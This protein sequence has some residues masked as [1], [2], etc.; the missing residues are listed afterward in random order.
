[1]SKYTPEEVR[2]L[3]TVRD[4]IL[5]RPQFYQAGADFLVAEFGP[6]RLYQKAV[7]DWER[8]KDHPTEI[9]ANQAIARK[10]TRLTSDPELES[11][12]RDRIDRENYAAITRMPDRAKFTTGQSACKAIQALL[13]GE[14]GTH[15]DV[16]AKAILL[17]AVMLWDNDVHTRHPIFSAFGDWGV[18]P[19][20][21]VETIDRWAATYFLD[22]LDSRKSLD[23]WMA[24]VQMAW[25]GLIH[26]DSPDPAWEAAVQKFRDLPISAEIKDPLVKVFQTVVRQPESFRSA[27]SEVQKLIADGQEKARQ[28]GMTDDWSFWTRE[29]LTDVADEVTTGL[30]L[31]AFV[32]W[33]KRLS[34][35]LAI[36][37]YPGDLSAIGECGMVPWEN[38]W[39]EPGADL[40]ALP[41]FGRV[42]IFFELDGTLREQAKDRVFES[43][44]RHFNQLVQGKVVPEH[45]GTRKHLERGLLGQL[46]D[47]LIPP[48][49]QSPL[50]TS[51]IIENTAPDPMPVLSSDRDPPR[52]Q[53]AE[54]A[55]Q[56][57][58]ATKEP[59]KEALAAYRISIQTGKKQ[60]EIAD[61]LSRE[62]HRQI[63][64][65]Q[66]SKWI[67]EV[68]KYLEAGN[69]LP[70]MPVAA[71]PVPVDPGVIE[72]G[73]RGDRRAK[74][75]R[76]KYEDVL[77]D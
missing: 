32:E 68:K 24:N 12:E 70:D 19:N 75:Q 13:Y 27:A 39:A 43:H 9:A 66:V 6:D 61:I 20:G 52:Q 10:R 26:A 55:A 40:P 47:R 49:K 67:R 58:S 14:D 30:A 1:M 69:V 7:E 37:L 41:S 72:M 4:D 77:D 18:S 36:S 48:Q 17:M 23:R 25:A 65:G 16:R 15:N 35:L 46:V 45:V 3:A 64:Q 60:Q 29:V 50:E 2:L 21:K 57:R 11:D 38:R 34:I 51:G 31:P 74:H 62:F 22:D 28:S 59:S 63:S 44:T 71:R 42:A 8:W 76:G 53:E 56:P 73:P 5:R 54:D 33:K